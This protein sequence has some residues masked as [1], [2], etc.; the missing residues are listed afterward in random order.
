M[1]KSK[2]TT[3]KRPSKTS[4]SGARKTSRSPARQTSLSNFGR[5][6]LVALLIVETIWL[7][8]FIRN[9]GEWLP[10]GESGRPEEIARRRSEAVSAPAASVALPKTDGS[11]AIEI[12]SIP[13]VGDL[14]LSEEQRDSRRI[15]DMLAG[16]VK[17]ASTDR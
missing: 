5:R 2:K 6:F 15:R 13:K 11:L 9:T 16:G 17:D 1:F 8:L 12:P 14:L 4:R 10:L 7:A 3:T